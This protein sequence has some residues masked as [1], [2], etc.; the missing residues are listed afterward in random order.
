MINKWDRYFYGICEAVSLNSKCL[1]RKIGA[2]LVKDRSVIATSYNGPPR[3]IPH[4]SSRSRRKFLH[5]SL[6][7]NS[8]KREWIDS[9]IDVCPRKL[10]GFKSGEGLDICNAAHSERN[11]IN[12]CARLGISVEGLDIYMNASVTPCKECILELIQVGISNVICLKSEPY[13]DIKWLIEFSNLNIREFY[14]GE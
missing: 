10:M 13:N 14:L 9:E 4:C 11:L 3:G 12:Q 5:E 7:E 1:S 8:F 6:G 2:I